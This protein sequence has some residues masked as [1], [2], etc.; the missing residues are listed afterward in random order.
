[1]S[2][3]SLAALRAR[4]AVYAAFVLN[5]AV[6][7]AWISRIPSVRDTLGLS[8]GGMSV[9]LLAMAVGSVVTMPLAGAVVLRIGP[10]R[11]VVAGACTV[12]LGLLLVSTSVDGFG[13]VAPAAVGLFL[14]GAGTASWDVA[15]NVEGSAV[16]RRLDR[17]IMSRFHAAWSL[18]SVLSAG[19]A[20]L[21]LRLDVPTWAHLGAIALLGV[22]GAAVAT[23]SFLP[24]AAP[25]TDEDRPAGSITLGQAWREPRTL[26]IG[27]LVLCMAFVEGTANDWLALGIVDGH[28]ASHSTGVAGFTVFVVAMTLG[29]VGGP[30]V[31]DRLGRVVALR[32]SA[33]VAAVGVVVFVLSPGVAVA[34]AGALLWGLGTALGFPTGMSAAG[35]EEVNA[36]VRVSVVSSVGYTAFLAGP[37]VLGLLADHVGVVHAV[38]AAAVAAVVALFVAAATAPHH[39]GAALGRGKLSS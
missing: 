34:V 8:N 13:L 28:D 22:A 14:T 30:V 7:S 27:V 26:V 10:A 18:G 39:A 9:L 5:G 37:P 19:L 15:M 29:R 16:E 38:T 23:R 11:T 31:L 2:G 3:P 12:A 35:D 6:T 4:T 33:A 36:A 25:A 17:S 21:L 1:M 24:A 20:V 32:L